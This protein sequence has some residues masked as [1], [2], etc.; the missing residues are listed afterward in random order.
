MKRSASSSPPREQSRRAGDVGLIRVEAFDDVESVEVNDPR[1]KVVKVAANEEMNGIVVMERG[2][3]GVMTTN[4]GV[5]YNGVDEVR[6]GSY[7]II[8]PHDDLG[9]VLGQLKSLLHVVR[10]HHNIPDVVDVTGM[11]FYD[12]RV[13]VI[14]AFTGITGLPESTAIS[15]LK[16]N[17]FNL[18]LALTYHYEYGEGSGIP[19]IHD[20]P[21]PPHAR[22]HDPRRRPGPKY[23]PSP[24]FKKKKAPPPHAL[25]LRTIARRLASEYSHIRS[26]VS[27]TGPITSITLPDD[28][29]CSWLV[30]MSFP[31]TAFQRELDELSRST[32][33]GKHLVLSVKFPHG[34]PM[35][36]P[37]VAVVEPRV[38]YQTVPVSFGGKVAIHGLTRTGWQETG[39]SVENVLLNVHKEFENAEVCRQTCLIKGYG[40]EVI[41]RTDT[42]DWETANGF[43]GRYV[44]CVPPA[45]FGVVCSDEY[46]RIVLPAEAATILYGGRLTL[47]LIFEVS[48]DNGRKRHCGISKEGFQKALPSG[49]VVL[50]SWVAA[51]LFVKQGD[52]VRVRCV[53]VPQVK[54]VKLQPHSKEFY[55]DAALCDS[56]AEALQRGL[57]G[58]ASLTQD[59]TVPITLETMEGPKL[60]FFEVKKL[61]PSGAARLITENPDEE[62]EFK[63]D[64]E[65]APDHE[66]EEDRLANE[67]K[68]R[69]KQEKEAQRVLK[70]AMNME[71]K[72]QKQI[73]DL[74]TLLVDEGD[75]NMQIRFPDGEVLR[76]GLPTG[77]D[78]KLLFVHAACRSKWAVQNKLLPNKIRLFT[79]FPRTEVTSGCI[80]KRM[81][82]QTFVVAL[83]EDNSGMERADSTLSTMQSFDDES[84][85]TPEAFTNTLMELRIQY[86]THDG[87]DRKEA[88]RHM[89][90]EPEHSAS[91]CLVATPC[92]DMP[93]VVNEVVPVVRKEENM[94][95][96][97][98]GGKETTVDSKGLV[99]VKGTLASLV[100]GFIDNAAEYDGGSYV[101]D[102]IRVLCEAA[103]EPRKRASVSNFVSMFRMPSNDELMSEDDSF[104]DTTEEEEEDPVPP[105][106]PPPPAPTAVVK[107]EDIDT[108]K[109]ILPHLDDA[110]ITRALIGSSNLDHAIAR[111]LS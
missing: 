104:E 38:K 99:E 9:N 88:L 71:R 17:R 92:A 1:G 31:G 29:F 55:T 64:F 98:K 84:D 59:T 16:Q 18:D 82:K 72:Y 40:E 28:T 96:V 21:P 45:P 100:L 70:Q 68:L 24:A 86:Y 57:K 56:P 46:D 101:G 49:H 91:V 111:L 34:Y 23:Y 25:T 19:Q 79:S 110:A 26:T 2:K 63:V 32:H 41:E 85:H 47:P 7:D 61:N 95:R 27:P 6:V 102:G 62:I 83:L 8:V 15:R 76:C 37:T 77:S 14:Q 58:M 90:S 107:Q 51:D 80:D 52:A 50:P 74:Q 93:L 36:P 78:V 106:P 54:F 48:T 30:H 39:E 109:S 5:T 75:I 105:P 43:D 103:E 35:I 33:V 10:G 65:A 94:W 89:D 44:A 12:A 87:M 22:H 3:V 67:A 11:V 13:E 20:Q 42:S 108:V 53:S 4:I 81:D 60:H 97:S 73:E 69:V 66:E